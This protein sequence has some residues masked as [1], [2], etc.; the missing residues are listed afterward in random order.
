MA[1]GGIVSELLA[2]IA[3]P[4]CAT[5]GAAL[6][7]AG[8]VM[9]PDCRR[10]LPWLRGPRCPRCALPAPCRPCPAAGA[11]FDAAWAPMAYAGTAREAV[12]RLKFGRALALVDLMAAQMA[13]N[14]PAQLVRGR[15]VVAVPLHRSRRRA[16][17]FNQAE[18]LA[19]ALARRLEL[20]LG[21][22]LVR[23][24]PPSRQAGAGRRA[25]LSGGRLE[26]VAVGD[27]PGRALLVDDVHTTGATLDAC[28]RALR[29]RGARSVVCLAYARALP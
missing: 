11:A 21:P 2:L 7:P 22:C 10:A 9:C 5:C 12:A 4:A 15:M 19:G 23:R 18:R 26:V 27:A 16:R 3:P 28:A 1:C 8:E 14:A 24:G 6:G 13:A 20:P 25:R 17:G 29:R